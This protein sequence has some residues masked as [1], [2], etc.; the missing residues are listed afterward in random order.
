[1]KSFTA[2]LALLAASVMAMPQPAP[3]ITA[4]ALLP[5]E[6]V[7]AAANNGEKGIEAA[8]LAAEAV[9]LAE[10]GDAGAATNNAVFT[11]IDAQAS[12]KEAA[13][14]AAAGITTTAAAAAAA[15]AATTTAAAK[16]NKNAKGNAN[17]AAKNGKNAK[18]N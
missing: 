17:A 6:S 16:D 4:P 2:I 7:N 12:A 9:S 14:L 13:D 15:A 3:A 8:D 18:G 5:R 11:S 1:M 10:A